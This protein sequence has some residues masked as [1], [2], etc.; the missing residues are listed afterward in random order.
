MRVCTKCGESKPLAA[1][2]RS[3]AAKDGFHTWCKVCKSAQVRE[4]YAKNAEAIRGRERDRYKRNPV[5]DKEKTHR[6]Y[7]KRKNESDKV[8]RSRRRWKLRRYGVTIEDYMQMFDA[9]GGKCALCGS[10]PDKRRHHDFAVDHCH[11][12]GVVR[13]L[14]CHRCNVGLGH[15]QDNPVLLMAAAEYL[16]R[17][18]TRKTA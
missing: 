9:Q 18:G 8:Y 7:N 6:S 10:D 17:H 11:E 2:A 15:F 13:G 14:L 12:S 1:F 4:W 3:N 16:E 5:P